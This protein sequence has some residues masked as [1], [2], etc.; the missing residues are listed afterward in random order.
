MDVVRAHRHRIGALL[1]DS[2]TTI[3]DLF[4]IIPLRPTALQL[5]YSIAPSDIALLAEIGAGI[6]VSDYGPF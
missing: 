1:L 5:G 6:D 4:M 3:G 2:T